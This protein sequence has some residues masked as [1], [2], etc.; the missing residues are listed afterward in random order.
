M[1][2][3]AL[4][5]VFLH[6]SNGYLT[7]QCQGN[8]RVIVHLFEWKWTDIANECEAYL[9]P[10]GYCAVQVS[11]PMEHIQ[12]KMAQCVLICYFFLLRS[13]KTALISSHLYFNTVVF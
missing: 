11:P 9:G 2:P 7:P 8:R 3:A 5:S 6:T 13:L 1:L 4:V 10:K 12:G